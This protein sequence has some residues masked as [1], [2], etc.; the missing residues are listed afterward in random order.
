MRNLD[1]SLSRKEEA[2]SECIKE[3][4]DIQSKAS[5]LESSLS[6]KAEEING[7]MEEKVIN[8]TFH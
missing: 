4:N 8:Y 5:S 3:K 2:L 1:T 7:L 6:R